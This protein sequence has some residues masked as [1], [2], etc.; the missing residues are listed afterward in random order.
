MEEALNNGLTGILQNYLTFIV[1]PMVGF[2]DDYS[3]ELMDDQ[4]SKKPDPSDPPFLRACMQHPLCPGNITWDF[5][6]SP[7]KY[8]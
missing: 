5:G 3:T 6:C 1:E 8:K 7:T 4:Y 2:D